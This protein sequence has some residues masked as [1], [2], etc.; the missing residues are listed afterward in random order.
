MDNSVF[1]TVPLSR[2]AFISTGVRCI[3]TLITRALIA[4]R[5]ISSSQIAK[6]ISIGVSLANDIARDQV[7]DQTSLNNLFHHSGDSSR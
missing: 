4:C 5:G 3:R 6:V 7:F 1:T 2:I